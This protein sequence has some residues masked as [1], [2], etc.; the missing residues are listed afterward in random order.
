M[1]EPG[2]VSSMNWT[3][4]LLQ[5]APSTR[6]GWWLLQARAQQVGEGGSSQAMA[7]WNADGRPVAAAMQSVALFG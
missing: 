7:I 4:N 2:P 5:P 3:L 1:A 6:D